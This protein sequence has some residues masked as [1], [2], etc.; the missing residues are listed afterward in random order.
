M[1]RGIQGSFADKRLK[2]ACQHVSDLWFPVNGALLAK[3]RDGLRTGAYERDIEL[4]LGE[5]KSDLSLFTYCLRELSKLLKQEQ[6]AV[7]SLANPIEF[8][9]NAG[10]QRLRKILDVN[11]NTVSRHAL[12]TMSSFQKVRLEEALVSASTAEVLATDAGLDPV[13]GFSAAI[14]R[15][16]GHTLIAWNYPTV[17]QRALGSLKRGTD[18]DVEIARVLGFTPSV[19]AGAIIQE[20]GIHPELK[21]V[22]TAEVPVDEDAIGSEVPA[23]A[24]TLTTICKV[25]EALARANHPDTYPTALEDWRFA[26]SE[27]TQRI[28]EEGLSAIK[29]RFAESCI[30]YVELVPQVFRG[31][32]ILDPEVQVLKH[33]Q[34]TLLD[35][36]PYVAQCQPDLRAR[37]QELYERIAAGPVDKTNIRVLTHE[38]IPAAGFRGGCVYTVDP[39]N[40]IL[41]PQLE[42]KPVRMRRVAAVPFRDFDD[43][44]DVIAT[45][46]QC[47]API[48]QHLLEP[49]EGVGGFIAG[50][51]GFSQRVGVLYLELP[52]DAVDDAEANYTVH[53]K[54]IAQALNDALGLR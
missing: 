14:L 10:L 17:Y 45:A 51:L 52:E 11:E 8:L 31:G 12:V 36:N 33:R 50:V 16:L 44:G 34:G 49:R 35:H 18:L 22:V 5:V 21:S 30:S 2:R 24:Q 27:I 54:A 15:Q 39:A 40:R 9:R 47:N 48:A 53:F 4:L 1:E 19:L 28:G 29:E 3:I 37:L 7:G 23:I 42:M 32:M 43:S 25:G 13:V 41:I 38:I 46:F 20:W 6:A 26:K